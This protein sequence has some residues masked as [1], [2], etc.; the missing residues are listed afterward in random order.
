MR[1]TVGT[2]D[3]KLSE[4]VRVASADL[5][6]VGVDLK[7]VDAPPAEQQ[8]ADLYE[9]IRVILESKE[10]ALA[11]GAALGII[12]AEIVKDVYKG[13][14]SMIRTVCKNLVGRTKA[15]G[16][17][18]LITRKSPHEPMVTADGRQLTELDLG[19]GS[20]SLRIRYVASRHGEPWPEF[21][22][23]SF[24]EAM[25]VYE[26]VIGPI[27]DYWMRDASTGSIRVQGEF[28]P[29]SSARCWLVSIDRRGDR[30]IVARVP[31]DG[32]P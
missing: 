14:K 1:V 24:D 17:T 3:A 7:L 32:H 9:T 23:R 2:T 26:E 27:V 10:I 31:L 28:G 21:S 20:G 5:H 29:G 11:G 13:T 18:V 22:D 6:V 12:G 15:D 25:A 8:F 19:P 16:V 4:L 30:P